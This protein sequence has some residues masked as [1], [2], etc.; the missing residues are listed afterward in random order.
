MLNAKGKRKITALP[1]EVNDTVFKTKKDQQKLRFKTLTT[2]LKIKSKPQ[3][4]FSQMQE[5]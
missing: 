2:P 1:Q 4:K 3:V 5:N